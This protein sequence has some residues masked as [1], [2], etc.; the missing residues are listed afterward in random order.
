MS[1]HTPVINEREPLLAPLTEPTEVRDALITGS[2][3]YR[4]VGVETL[5]A[6]NS[7][8]DA[9][10]GEFNGDNN[11][12]EEDDDDTPL[13]LGQI[14][15]LCY[16]RLVEPVA[17]F[18]VFAFL[19]QMLWEIGDIGKGDVGFY[20]GLIESL[21]SVT[22]MILM[23]HWGR[24]SDK[25]GRKPIMIISLL[26]ISFA[27][28]IFGFG[29]SIGQLIMFRCIAGLFAGTIVTIRTMISEN[30]T[31][32]TQA[33]AFSYFSVAGNL[34][35]L[36]GPLIGGAMSEPAKQYPS[37]FGGVKF[38]EEFPFALPT[39]CTGLFALSSTLVA[40]FYIKE[41]LGKKRYQKVGARDGMTMRE[42]LQF[43]GVARCIYISCHVNL[44]S[45]IYTSV[46]SVFWFTPVSLGGL[47]FSP[48]RIS[49]FIALAGFSQA[50]WMIVVFP[51]LHKRVGTVGILR[52]CAFFWPFLFAFCPF[53]N[54]LLRM[55]W[56]TTFWVVYPISM[57]MGVGVSMAFTCG[58]LALNDIAPSSENLGTLNSIALAVTSGT[59]AFVPALFTIIFAY[60]VTHQI[61]WG[62]FIWVFE[63]F[64]AIGLVIAVQF[65][66][67][68]AYGR[69]KK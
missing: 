58:Q 49:L 42:L 11:G 32:K 65:L 17:F 66:P 56:E 48:F 13:P 26:G 50:F 68:E 27:T 12:D 4:D 24:A 22:E 59:R 3:V 6:E 5:R 14:L 47:G 25:F 52:A 2:Q 51:P 19:N 57:S 46:L 34:G 7:R 31:K 33:R 38:F 55:G 36:V 43:P 39:I 64:V 1:P 15:G 67:K 9:E 40:T 29:R 61:L 53:A 35:I 18:S 60:G 44:M 28:G 63:I 16:I 37:L 54:F 21:F 8:R 69:G 10:G 45:T 62:Y 30:S 23:V 41:T 20:S